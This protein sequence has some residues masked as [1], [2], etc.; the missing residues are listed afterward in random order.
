MADWVIVDILVW[1]MRYLRKSLFLIIDVEKGVV[2]LVDFSMLVMMELSPKLQFRDCLCKRNSHLKGLKWAEHPPQTLIQFTQCTYLSMQ[3]RVRVS[4]FPILFLSSSLC[5]WKGSQWFDTRIELQ[6]HFF[7][8]NSSSFI[9][10]GTVRLED[11][12]SSADWTP[13]LVEGRLHR[14]DQSSTTFKSSNIILWQPGKPGFG[15]EKSGC[16][17]RKH[18][19]LLWSKTHISQDCLNV[20]AWLL[21]NNFVFWYKLYSQDRRGWD[22]GVPTSPRPERSL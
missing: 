9:S 10:L 8:W 14:I 20:V 6:R 21:V 12:V 5:G 15:L 13:H 3:K 17:E 22:N 18:I 11:S 7:Y 19:V 16:S 1:L 2:G 4:E